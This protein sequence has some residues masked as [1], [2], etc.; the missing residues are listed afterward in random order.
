MHAPALSRR[1][2]R[3]DSAG[4]GELTQGRRLD[5]LLQEMLREVNT[6]GQKSADLDIAR[7][8]IDMKLAIEQMREQ[9]QNL[10]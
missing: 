10:L 7:A 4:E 3:R 5:F 2:A 9:S 6:I 8:V 1:A